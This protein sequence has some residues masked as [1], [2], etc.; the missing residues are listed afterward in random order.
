MIDIERFIIV[1]QTLLG[2][3]ALWA[4]LYTAVCA[5]AKKVRGG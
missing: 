3:F 4:L 2:V 5:V 1:I